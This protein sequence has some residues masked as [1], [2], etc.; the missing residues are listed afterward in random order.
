[1]VATLSCEG[2]P[3]SGSERG[4]PC[5]D[6]DLALHDVDA[7]H[8]FG[9]RVLDLNPRIDL[10]EIKVSRVGVDEKLDGS[11]VLVAQLPA[12]GERRLAQF[13][14]DFGIQIGSRRDLDNLL[15]PPLDRTIPLEEMD[16]IS[17]QVAQ[18]LDFDVAGAAGCT[19]PETRPRSRRPPATRAAPA[20]TRAANSSGARTTRMPRPPPPFDALMM[21]GNSIFWAARSPSAGVA[22]GLPAAGEDRNSRA[23]RDGAGGDLVA[24]LLQEFRPRTDEDDAGLFAGPGEIGILG[25]E[26]VARM[27]RVDLP[28]LGQRDQHGN[29]QVR[30]DRL[31]GV[32][33]QI[34]FIRLQPVQSEAVFVGINADGPDAQLMAGPEDSD[35]NFAA[36]GN[37]K[38]G[39]APH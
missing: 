14:A 15:M 19:F 35:G 18:Q 7:G 37:E 10:D 16:E 36:I 4:S 38:S 6:Q 22:H 30:L 20:R 39:D 13:L 29:I 27:N 24:Q 3:I 23:L 25:K 12:D 5:G 34:G 33:D 28:F 1:M 2:S 31:A 11:R 32:A 21:T 9:D 17:V 8:L 26:T